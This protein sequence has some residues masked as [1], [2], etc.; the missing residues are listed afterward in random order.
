[1]TSH[2]CSEEYHK[3][4]ISQENLLKLSIDSTEAEQEPQA[5]KLHATPTYQATP[6]LLLC[7]CSTSAPDLFLFFLYSK[8]QGHCWWRHI[9]YKTQDRFW[10]HYAKAKLTGSP[11]V[12]GSPLDPVSPL[13]PCPN[14]SVRH[15]PA[16]WWHMF[17]DIMF[18]GAV[19]RTF[20]AVFIISSYTDRRGSLHAPEA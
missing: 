7:L 16:G 14:T 9:Q 3:R 1:M 20:R 11:L 19:W 2:A 12:P 17:R 10:C 5:D 13:P 6:L 4:V 18:L 8:I 15:F